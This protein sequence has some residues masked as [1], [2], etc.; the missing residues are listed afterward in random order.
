MLAFF[1]G[2]NEMLGRQGRTV[3]PLVSFQGLGLQNAVAV[4]MAKLRLTP[5]VSPAVTSTINCPRIFLMA[6][7]KVEQI[8]Y[9]EI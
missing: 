6:F 3:Q 5:M 8:N 2:E 4:N 9:L 1:P 7:F